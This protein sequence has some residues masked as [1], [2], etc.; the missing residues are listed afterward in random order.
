MMMTSMTLMKSLTACSSLMLLGFHKI[1]H[2]NRSTGNSGEP[3]RVGDA[4]QGVEEKANARAQEKEKA[5]TLESLSLG[6]HGMNLKDTGRDMKI[7][8]TL[9]KVEKA[10]AN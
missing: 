9:E 3:R 1:K 6:I 4:G 10:R 2:K 8:L 7:H 5:N